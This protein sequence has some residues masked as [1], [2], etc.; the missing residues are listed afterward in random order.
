MASSTTSCDRQSTR[1][2]GPSEYASGVIESC[3]IASAR[4]LLK[5]FSRR[6]GY[7]NDSK[8]ARSIVSGWLSP[9]GCWEKPEELNDLG[10]AI[11][12]ISPLLS[13]RSHCPHLSVRCLV[14][15]RRI[16]EHLRKISSPNRSLAYDAALFERCVA[17]IVKIIESENIDEDSK[18]E[19]RIF[20]SLFPIYF[21]VRTRQLNNDCRSLGR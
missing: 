5:S 14:R 20:A 4:T 1:G 13:R 3:S 17:L 9:E 12:T 21:L 19:R 18:E 16:S 10:Y 11:S 7:L 6:L 2:D 15:R 8:E